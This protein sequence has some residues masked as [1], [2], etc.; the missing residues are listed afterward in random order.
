MNLEVREKVDEKLL[1]RTRYICD[2]DNK[3]TPTR[4]EARKAIAAKLGA[5]PKKLVI[6]KV[7][8][9]FGDTRYTIEAK[10]YESEK[11][12]KDIELAHKVLRD[13]KAEEAG[14]K[15]APAQ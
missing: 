14:A 1:H 13:K 4:L 6:D 2:V 8:Q 9:R 10:V 12:L 5:D 15:A 7:H 11:H 3:T